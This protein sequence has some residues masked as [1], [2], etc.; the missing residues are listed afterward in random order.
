MYSYGELAIEN[1]KNSQDAPS[2]FTVLGRKPQGYVGVRQPLRRF[3]AVCPHD[4][5][6][7]SFHL[8]FPAVLKCDTNTKPR[9]EIPP[10]AQLAYRSKRVHQPFSSEVNDFYS[11][12]AN[13]TPLALSHN[14]LINVA[15]SF[16]ITN[17]KWRIL[18]AH[19]MDIIG[20]VL[21]ILEERKECGQ[22]CGGGAPA[23]CG[24]G[25]PVHGCGG[26]CAH[27]ADHV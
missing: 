9:Q 7:D 27:A 1:I 19:P 17:T 5:N 20:P 24:E 23:E 18:P 10:Q 8:A 16:T 26:A 12:Y 11:W 21:I 25:G 4:K 6:I 15:A 2:L 22:W 3:T 14:V 13:G